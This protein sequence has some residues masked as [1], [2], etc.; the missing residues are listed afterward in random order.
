ML[1]QIDTS[2]KVINEIQKLVKNLKMYQ[3]LRAV[4]T[5]ESCVASLFSRF[6][7]LSSC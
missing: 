5:L 7:S 3:L 6:L 2:E 1:Y 4:N